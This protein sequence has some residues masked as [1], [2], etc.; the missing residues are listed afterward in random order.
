MSV[1]SALTLRTPAAAT[2]LGHA[3]HELVER[4][5]DV[6]EFVHRFLVSRVYTL[7]PVRPGLFVMSRPGGA[8][9]VPVWSTVRALR[10]VMGNYDWFARTGE[11]LVVHLPDGVGVLIDDGM[12]CP[13]ALP[14]SVLLGQRCGSSLV[15]GS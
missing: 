4:Q 6:D 8:A 10:Q 3:V 5:I 2:E 7:C 9:I 11:D 15:V 14:S 13:V 12:P 1:T